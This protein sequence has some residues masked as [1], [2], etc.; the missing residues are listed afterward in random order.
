[1]KIHHHLGPNIFVCHF[2]QSQIQ[3]LD[4]LWGPVEIM[5][6]PPTPP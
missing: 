3:V 2:F 6:G 1:M 5:A 4:G